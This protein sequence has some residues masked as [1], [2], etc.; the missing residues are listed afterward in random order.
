MLAALWLG[1]AAA[2]A[3]PLARIEGV[4][5]AA[6][7]RALSRAV[8]EADARPSGEPDAPWRARARA[9]EASDILERYLNSQGYYGCRRSA[10]G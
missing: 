2:M 5:D 3:E 4:E 9:R 8:G 10:R 7:A 1:L 6:L